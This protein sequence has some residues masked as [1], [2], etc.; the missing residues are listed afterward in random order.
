ML[1][2]SFGRGYYTLMN[3]E[4][5]LGLWCCKFV[6]IKV[7]CPGKYTK[8]FGNEFCFGSVVNIL[9]GYFAYL[10]KTNQVRFPSPCEN[11][12]WHDFSV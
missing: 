6:C 5:I 8:E 12:I 11:I 3:S 2:D 9:E 10:L 7:K 1:R 4:T